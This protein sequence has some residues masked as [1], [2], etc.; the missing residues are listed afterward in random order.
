MLGYFYPVFRPNLGIQFGG[1]S[2]FD[3][4]GSLPWEI[5]VSDYGWHER[6]PADLDLR[7]AKLARNM[8]LRAVVPTASYEFGYEGRDVTIDLRFDAVMEPMVTRAEPPYNK[9]HIDQIGRVTGTMVLRG[10]EIAVDAYS[11][12]DRSWGPRQDGRQ[13]KVGYAYATVSPV[14]A[15]LTVSVERAGDDAVSLGF[16]QRDGQWSK[17]VS[18]ERR[19]H[20]DE[21]GRPV[22]VTID[23]HDALGR[24]LHAEGVPVAGQQTLIYPS[25]LC[26]N[27]LMHWKLDGEDAWG[28]DQDIWHPRK[29]RDR[30]VTP[31]G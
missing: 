31:A 10:E 29:W 19:A 14:H 13:P 5:L 23:A 22:G 26:W 17:V 7:D 4:S 2:L 20:R 27:Q 18:G 25:M 30:H 8:W 9:G 16:L 6:M 15:F 24:S 3:A 28:E 21:A 1:I 12:R 11:M